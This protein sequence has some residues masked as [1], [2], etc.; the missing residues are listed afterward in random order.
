[1]SDGL[2]SDIEQKIH[3]LGDEHQN[4]SGM[5]LTETDLQCLLYKKLLEIELLGTLETTKDGHL[6]YPLHTELSWYDQNDHLALKPDITILM[7]DKLKITSQKNVDLPKKGFVF[8][9][10]GIIFE[11]KFNR[12]KATTAFKKALR[13]DIEKIEELQRVHPNTFCYFVWLNKYNVN[14]PEI[15]A[16]IESHSDKYKIIY[17]NGSINI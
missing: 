17:I 7:P 15:D 6:T 13:G 2:R 11:L 3:E 8:S 14:D 12:F 1:M 5:I 4:Y 10:G 16:L 9:G